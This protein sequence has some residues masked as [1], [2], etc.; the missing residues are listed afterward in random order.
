MQSGWKTAEVVISDDAEIVD[1]QVS[2]SSLSIN[3]PLAGTKELLTFKPSLW[4][5][6]IDLKEL[7]RRLRPSRE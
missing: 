4:G 1:S 6:S 3:A 7:V 5:I 2:V